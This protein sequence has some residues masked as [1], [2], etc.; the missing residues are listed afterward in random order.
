[1]RKRSTRPS[2]TW[3]SPFASCGKTA[4]IPSNR[5]GPEFLQPGDLLFYENTY[6]SHE[7]ITHVGIYAG[8]G[9]VIMATQPG[10]FVKEVSMEDSYWSRHFVSAGRPVKGPQA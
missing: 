8:N 9:V 4:P 7:R 10:E 6:P 1:M 3:I 5:V 2:P